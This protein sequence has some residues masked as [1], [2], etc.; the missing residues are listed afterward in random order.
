MPS[1]HEIQI[2]LTKS[3]NVAENVQAVTQ[4][5]DSAKN[6]LLVKQAAEYAQNL[7]RKVKNKD[8]LLLT[9]HI[10]WGSSES[11]NRLIKKVAQN[12]RDFLQ[13]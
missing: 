11:R 4:A 3:V 7:H 10:G 5:H 13:G 2:M 6:I 1:T 12:I 9:P 8:R